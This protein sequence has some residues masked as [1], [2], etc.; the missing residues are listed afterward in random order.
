MTGDDIIGARLLASAAI[1]NLVPAAQIKAGRLPENAPLPSLL[2]RSVTT[3]ERLQLKRG[4]RVFVRER[5][6]VTVRAAS[7]RER[8]AIG[9]LL[10]TA[11][12]G[13]EAASGNETNISVITAGAGPEVDG[14]GNSFERGHDFRVSYETPA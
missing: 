8:K 5:V 13:F 2:V 10:A 3:I 7:H 9:R 14:P 1:T 4:P 11:C 12:V 6:S